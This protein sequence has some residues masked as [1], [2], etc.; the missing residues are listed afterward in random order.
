MGDSMKKLLILIL[1]CFSLQAA[2]EQ[3]SNK[4]L[5]EYVIFNKIQAINGIKK[6][7]TKLVI[8]KNLIAKNVDKKV[9]LLVKTVINNH[10][11]NLTKPIELVEKHQFQTALDAIK[12]LAEKYH[13]DELDNVKDYLQNIINILANNLSDI[14]QISYEKEFPDNI[15]EIIN[16]Y[17]TPYQYEKLETINIGS[18]I[19]VAIALSPDKSKL[20]IDNNI[21]DFKSGRFLKKLIGN[22]DLP[23][24]Q[25]VFSPDG[26]KIVSAEGRPMKGRARIWDI[27][28]GNELC[29]L[30]GHTRSVRSVAISPNNMYVASSSDDYTIRIWDL[31][32]GIQKLLIQTNETINS[33]SFSPDSSKIVSGGFTNQNDFKIR[34]WDVNSGNEL[35]KENIKNH[36]SVINCVVFSPDGSKIASCAYD[37]TIKIW[38]VQSG[39]LFKELIGHTGSV[40]KVSFSDD[41][42]KIISLSWD[43]NTIRIWDIE[44]GTELQKIENIRPMFARFSSNDSKIIVASNQEIQIWGKT[45]E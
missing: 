17:I 5:E 44:S 32:S 24:Q 14:I 20:V 9:K 16:K 12:N 3:L 42:S 39:K 41:G 8:K 26:S 1:L 18:R 27:E 37:G 28:S 22:I 40:E 4:E 11:K 38:D 19:D 35:D 34:I 2:E 29:K 23:I 31:E 45:Y 33:V 43:D 7:I 25:L 15:S 10:I 6:Q 21:Y 13:E 36:K 30:L